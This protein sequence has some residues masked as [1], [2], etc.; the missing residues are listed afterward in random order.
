MDIDKLE[1][2]FNKLH[3]ACGG[4]D[5]GCG[6]YLFDGINYTYSRDLY[7]DRQKILYDVAK[8]SS[9]TLEIGTYMGHSLL[10][11]LLANPDIS[12]VGIDINDRYSVPAIKYLQKNFIN[13][14]IKFYKGN[15]LDVLPDLIKKN[16]SFDLFHID[17]NHLNSFIT[18][19]FKY[20]IKLLNKKKQHGT[21][22]R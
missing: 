2:H 16:Q 1:F 3:E 7:F 11:M 5:Y 15:S 21:S 6:S 4:F 19:E 17:G 8:E 13:S 10:I 14:N 18:K 12:I 20:C 9:S 22:F